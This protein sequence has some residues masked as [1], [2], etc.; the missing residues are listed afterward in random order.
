MKKM[1]FTTLLIF[2][3]GMA[4]AQTTYYWVGGVGPISFTA[5]SNWNTSQD[6]S[7]TVRAAADPTDI[8]IFSGTNVGGTTPTTGTVTVLATSASFGQLRIINNA[9]VIISRTGGGTATLTL[10]GDASPADDFVVAAGCSL[11]M[12]TALADG[13]IIIPMSAGATGLVNGTITISNTG[14]HRIT[15]QTTNGLVFAAGAT[16]NS[17]GI[18]ASAA[19]P[20]GSS[21]QGIQNGVVF[22]NG[23]N[24]IITGNRSPM[25][26]TSTFQACNMLPGSNTYFRSNA[27]SATGSYVNQKNYGNIFVEN[28]T[29]LTSDG[30]LSKV[31][32]LTVESGSSFI[33]HTSGITPVL[34]NL[35][36]NGSFTAPTGSTNIL[37]MGGSAPQTISGSGTINVPSFTVSNYSSVTLAKSITVTSICNI[38]GSINFGTNNQINGSATFTSRV[39][40][41]A[42][43][44]TG[45]TTAG[46]FLITGIPA[47]VLTGVAGLAITGPGIDA[48]TNVASFSA[49]NG[50]INLSKPAIA[51]A[52]GATYNFTSDAATMITANANGMDSLTGSV[53]VTG[54]K[55]YQSGTNYIFN[56]ATLKPFGLTSGAN[57]TRVNVGF[58]QVNAPITFNVWPSVLNF[59][60]VNAKITMRPLDTI[61]INT[62][63]FING[64]FSNTNYIATDYNAVT[65]EQ[66]IVQYD[67]VLAPVTLP[68]GT[69]TNYLPVRLT[70]TS[71]ST[72]T[73]AVFEGIT[74]NGQITGT[75]L[76][77]V[78]KQRVVNAVW[79]INRL[80]GSGNCD[81]QLSWTNA[82]EGSTF[83]TL[84]NTDIGI[85]A[86][87]GTSYA[88][89]IGV[90]N[91]TTNTA[92]A[93]IANFTPLSIGAVPPSTPF[94]FN[95][96]AN[97]VYGAA[98][99]NGG[100]SSLNTTQPIVYSSSNLAVATIVAGNIHIVGAGTTDITASQASDGFYPATSITRSLIVDKAPLTITADNKTK[101]EGQVNP[102][103]TIT[104]TGF[105]LGENASVFTTAPTITTTAVTASTPGTYPI[106]VSNAQAANYNITYVN[107]TLT[108]QAN[109][110]LV[111]TFNALPTKTYGNADFT[112]AASS[113]NNVTP[114][115]FV[116]SNTSVATV[117]GNLVHIVGAGTTTITASQAGAVGYF[118]AANVTQPLV[119]NKANLTIRV[120]DTSKIEGTANPVFDFT[121]TGF[122]LGETP[123]SLTSLPTVN[124]VANTNS[125]PGYY[126][127]IPQNAASNNYAFIYTNG[128][129]TIL[130]KT[131]K[132]QQYFNAYQ[133]STN[134]LTIRAYSNTPVIGDVT[135]YDMLGRPVARKNI[136]MPIGFISADIPIPALVTGAYVV[137]IKGKA[138]NLVKTIAILK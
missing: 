131:G 60:T 37:I 87:T 92:T 96:L 7:G 83:T 71:V 81:V 88:A 104:Y 127:L 45:N 21:T 124:T 10:N 106:T 102:T 137:T 126:S 17:A 103:L 9:N 74:S 3:I 24:L 39:N 67:G 133:S 78:Q 105:V 120:K 75:A 79:N 101:F 136:L 49:A 130:P 11:T 86:N 129:L 132:D 116:S 18:P 54:T 19:Y 69:L 122:V 57:A 41:T 2:S 65:G 8:L 40:G 76:T 62:G 84:P 48:N 90:G 33:T 51:N 46:S 89:P 32:N 138:V 53:I 111:I 95:A 38:V 4:F 44:V 15:S 55:A 22:Q 70:P 63:A 112:I 109:Q 113:N 42:A 31:D 118:P 91:N 72:F 6:G 110:Q 5:N 117:V 12:N 1:L 125:S 56:G 114:I 52:T 47:G 50:T 80:V 66:S 64:A 128:R 99:F 100:A 97:K 16:F 36:I 68:I 30:P 85:I 23:A 73:A 119:V 29:T 108:V 134:V 28:N 43:S 94:V 58:V 98:D 25:G 34:G 135:V 35:T 61:R 59:L 20:F 77:A 123:T 107:G 26:G 13:N 14:T 27:S 93:T 82:L 115:T 121:Y